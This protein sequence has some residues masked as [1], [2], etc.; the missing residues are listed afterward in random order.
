[1]INCT[2]EFHISLVIKLFV[3][4]ILLLLVIIVK[5]NNTDLTRI[6]LKKYIVIKIR[7]EIKRM[8]ESC[9]N[10]IKFYKYFNLFKKEINVNFKPIN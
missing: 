3:I 4:I 6:K 1:M 9:K 5:K 2:L 7:V 8:M 10:V